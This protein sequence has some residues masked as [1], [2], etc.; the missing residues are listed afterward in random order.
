[1]SYRKFSV[2]EVEKHNKE[3]DCWIIIG[4]K[5]YDVTNFL[6]QHPGGKKVLLNVAGQDA[7]KQFEAFHSPQ[8]LKK[9]GP[10]LL[11]GELVVAKGITTVLVDFFSLSIYSYPYSCPYPIPSISR[12]IV[13]SNF[14]TSSLSLLFHTVKKSTLFNIIHHL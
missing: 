11:I 13:V 8:T 6:A 2:E 9:Y 14:Q 5:V 12:S 1:M 3:G 4:G 7:T 10:S